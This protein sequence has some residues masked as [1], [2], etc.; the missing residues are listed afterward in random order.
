MKYEIVSTGSK[1]NCIIIND[2]LMLDCGVPY[3]WLKKYI[4]NIKVIFISHLHSDHFKKTTIEKIAYERPNIIFVVGKYMVKDLLRCGIKGANIIV[5]PTEKWFD[6]NA[7]KVRLDY[8]YHD[9]PND[10]IHIEF[11]DGKKLLYATDTSSI[12]HI[13]A[14]DYDLYLIEGNYETND[15]I[16]E[17]IKEKKEKGEFCYLERVQETHLS[18]LQAINWLDKNKGANSEYVFIHQH[19][20]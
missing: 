5:L 14:K 1:G 8:L 11:K 4:K 9:V 19:Q 12:D 18:Q 20:D 15:D 16:R 3:R 6:L 2:Y 17:K 10:C 7:F 13:V